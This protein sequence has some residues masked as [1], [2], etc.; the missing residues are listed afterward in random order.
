MTFSTLFFSTISLI[1]NLFIFLKDL[2][3]PSSKYSQ[4]VSNSN[5][6]ESDT[7]IPRLPSVS[8]RFN[9]TTPVLATSP[10]IVTP[11]VGTATATTTT[12]DEDD[13][14]KQ[15]ISPPSARRIPIRFGQAPNVASIPTNSSRISS[16]V[17]RSS[18]LSHSLS[19][20]LQRQKTD[21]NDTSLSSDFTAVGSNTSSSRRAE[22]MAREAIQGI[23]RFQQQ[24]SNHSLP[25]NNNI[26]IRSP[27]LS[28]RVIVNLK[29]NQSVSL[30][31]RLLSAH[32]PPTRTASGL[33]CSRISPKNNLYHIPSLHEVQ[34]P[35][36][37][38]SII[39]DNSVQSSQS[40]SHTN[41]NTSNYK[42]E[43]RMEIPI[44]IITKDDQENRMELNDRQEDGIVNFNQHRT[45]VNELIPSSNTNQTL[46]SI[47]KRSTS[48]ETV[49][50]KNVSFMN[51]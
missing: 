27:V 3:R 4:N 26:F 31:S 19:N 2:L 22:A 14:I 1:R 30:D 23:V 29:N 5:A 6:E 9:V 17:L 46:K 48:R 40:P 24:H 8:R 43:F 18:P 37:T 35:S 34:L 21:L 41:S 10:A 13:T 47:L 36:Q 11:T 25:E 28:R 50:R 15:N 39:S 38:A 49:S 7:N 33:S 32:T 51:A 20:Q 42:N 45:I 44:T 16:A 12:D